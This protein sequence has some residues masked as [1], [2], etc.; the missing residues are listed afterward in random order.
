MEG[1][2]GVAAW[3]DGRRNAR[4]RRGVGFQKGTVVLPIR[5]FGNYAREKISKI[6]FELAYFLHFCKLKW[7]HL[8]CWYAR[9]SIRQVYK[10][11]LIRA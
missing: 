4:Q 2:K 7:S 9:L 1:P 8:Q 6:N 11:L 5:K 10:L 3:D